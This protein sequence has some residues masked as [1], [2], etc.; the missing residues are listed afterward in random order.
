MSH[1][2]LTGFKLRWKLTVVIMGV[3]LLMGL[4]WVG[5]RTP[6][7]AAPEQNPNL[8][9]IPDR[10]PDDNSTPQPPGSAPVPSNPNSPAKPGSPSQGDNDDNKRDISITPVEPSDANQ[11]QPQPSQPLQ[12][13]DNKGQNQVPLGQPTKGASNLGTST[14]ADLSLSKT[15]NNPTPRVGETITF[16]IVISNSGPSNASNVAMSDLLPT[17]LILSSAT[18]SRGSY[19][20]DIGLWVVGTIANS[21]GVTL[22]VVAMATEAGAVTNIAEITAAYPADPDSK[23]GNGLEGEDDRATTSIEALSVTSPV[24]PSDNNASSRTLVSASVP[25]SESFLDGLGSVAWLVALCLGLI[26]ILVGIIFL[27]RA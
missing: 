7:W 3:I 16:T 19:E 9:T 15:V 23:P 21:E 13:K 24:A 6:S 14:R 5:E 20:A 10:P 25:A 12:Q 18:P 26:L 1:S 27:N 4:L 17:G 8:Q 11:N 2:L 22:S